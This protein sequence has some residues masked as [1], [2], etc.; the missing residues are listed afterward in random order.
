MCVHR[1]LALGTFLEHQVA[2]HVRSSV[3][4]TSFMAIMP[5]ETSRQVTLSYLS[6]YELKWRIGHVPFTG[7]PPCV[8]TSACGHAASI[9]TADSCGSDMSCC[10]L[11]RQTCCQVTRQSD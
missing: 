6:P 1:G 5:I 10:R 9:A 11:T 8:S 4:D 7:P 3:C 2:Y